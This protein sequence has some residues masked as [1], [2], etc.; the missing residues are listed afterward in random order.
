MLKELLCHFAT[1]CEQDS[2]KEL[3]QRIAEGLGQDI[4]GYSLHWYAPLFEQTLK[5][6]SHQIPK[7]QC[8]IKSDPVEKLL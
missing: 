6:S 1:E 8:F 2:V 3:S 4:A 5:S 7:L